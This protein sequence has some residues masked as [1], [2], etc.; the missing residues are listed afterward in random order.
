MDSLCLQFAHLRLPLPFVPKNNSKRQRNGKTSAGKQSVNPPSPVRRQVSH[1]H[2]SP[3]AH[4]MSQADYP[5]N[6]AIIAHVDHGKTTLVDELLKQSGAFRENQR[7]PNAPWTPTTS[8]GARHHHP[9]QM[10]LGRVERHRIN[11][12]DTPAT[13]ISAARWSA[14]CR[15]STA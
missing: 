14:S 8:S 2:I 11:I 6:I 9:R 1:W 5:R 10:H 15:W 4:I 13:P 7:W 3:T 12:V